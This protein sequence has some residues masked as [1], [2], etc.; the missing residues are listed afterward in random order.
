MAG[1]GILIISGNSQARVIDKEGK[2]VLECVK[3]DQYIVDMARTK[4]KNKKLK[5]LYL[6]IILKY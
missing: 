3:G 2:K 1:D 5:K 6:N 4:V